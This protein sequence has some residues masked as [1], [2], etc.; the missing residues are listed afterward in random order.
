M[1]PRVERL[2]GLGV[3]WQNPSLYFCGVPHK[4]CL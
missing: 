2:Q 4:M 3:L 1:G